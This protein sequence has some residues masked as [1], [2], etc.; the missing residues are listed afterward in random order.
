MSTIINDRDIALEASLFRTTTTVA[1]VVA[2]G[3]TF[4]TAKNSAG[5]TA[6]DIILTTPSVVTLTATISLIYTAAAVKTWYYALNTSPNSWVEVGS[7][8]T[9][10]ITNAAFLAVIGTASS[11]TYKLVVTEPFIDTSYGYSTITYSKEASDPIVAS[12]SR[13]TATIPCDYGGTPLNFANTENT[14]TVS[15]GTVALTYTTGTPAPNTFSVAVESSANLTLGTQSSNPGGNSY[16]LSGITGITADV[17]KVVF[18]ISVYDAGGTLV[19]YTLSEQVVYTK[20]TNGLV[21]DD[22][23]VSYIEVTSPLI[24]KSTSSKELAGTHS[25]ITITGKQTVGSITSTSGYLTITGNGDTEAGL[26]IA[27]SIT[28]NINNTA[29]KEYYTINLYSK[30]DKLAT[31]GILLDTEIIPVVFSGSSA[32]NML[33]TND[34]HSIPTNAAGSAGIYTG[35]G[36]NIYVYEGTAALNYDGIGTA[37]GTWKIDS[38]TATSITIGAISDGGTFAIV[39]DHSNFIAATASIKYNITGTTANGTAFALTKTQT[40]ARALTGAIGASGQKSI[41][42]TA[43]KWSNTGVGSFVKA[44]TYTWGSQLISTDYPTGWTGAA[45]ISPGSGYT[46]YQ[47]SL[48][49]TADAGDTTT[50]VNWNNAVTNTIG[51]TQDGGIGPQGNSARTAYIVS[52]SA[53]PPGKPSNSYGDVAPADWSFSATSTLS[54]GYYMYQS[55]GI[56]SGMGTSNIVITW[57][58]PYLSNLKVGSLSAISANLGIINISSVGSLSNNRAWASTTPG[59]FLGYSGS[60]YKFDLNSGINGGNYLQWD[61]VNLS[62][63]GA[64]YAISGTIGGNMID[65]TGIRSPGYSNNGT[66]INGWKLT[67]TGELYAKSGTFSGSLN[68]ASI[69]GASGNFSGGLSGASITGVTGTFT[70]K[71]AAGSVDFKSSVGSTSG[72][73]TSPGTYDIYI[74]AGM[75]KM[76]VQ[77]RG[78]GGGGGGGL[79]R[80][81]AGTGGKQGDYAEGIFTVSAGQHYQL[82]IGSG[83]AGGQPREVGRASDL[84]NYGSYGT[85]TYVAGVLGANGGAGGKDHFHVYG[86]YFSPQAG[87]PGEG[88]FGG[89]GAPMQSGLAGSHGG[90]EGSGGGGGFT[91]N[92]APWHSE[93]WNRPSAGGWGGPGWAFLEFF[94][95]NGVVLKEPF[96]LLKTQIRAVSGWKNIT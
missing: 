33:L 34:S 76:R 86:T 89:A 81:G 31:G 74:P 17:A 47:L 72:P 60:A 8:L 22:A 71:L 83:G 63:N 44:F 42:I 19:P 28:T 52:A 88:P 68:G 20:V 26:A 7:G 25:N 64:M 92:H 6:A 39:A 62:I 43:F 51:Y 78:G 75:N 11:I 27:N 66:T 94:D 36:T 67:S 4:K 24:F 90:F 58:N 84:S 46:L 32:L 91:A 37:K 45:G 70:G 2:T 29:G 9:L 40:F 59:I 5:T 73:F 85:G 77:L 3:G 18:R 53:Y 87:Y 10:T 82:V 21:G 48:N 15:R 41:M 57:G 93:V 69:T 23:V 12:S 1:E 56:L 50:S 55:D 61:G 16:T 79:E 96:E 54:E 80:C 95:A 13:R 30:A 14:I 38:T 49:I 35:S 65:S